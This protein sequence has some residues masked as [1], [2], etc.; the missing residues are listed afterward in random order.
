MWNQ[1]KT[2]QMKW[3]TM[4]SC[5]GAAVDLERRSASSKHT[6]TNTRFGIRVCVCECRLMYDP[7]SMLV[8]MCLCA[9][10]GN[11]WIFAFSIGQICF[12]LSYFDGNVDCSE[13]LLTSKCFLYGFSS[14]ASLSSFSFF[15][16]WLTWSILSLAGSLF[17]LFFVRLLN[18]QWLSCN[19]LPISLKLLHHNS[20][21][22][23]R[24]EIKASFHR[25]LAI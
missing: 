5:A 12:R 16:L 4:A 25:I 3:T 18:R 8:R 22:I 2:K 24:S 17:L 19:D 10:D 20:I 15:S 1:E 9:R 7:V 6:A 14:L 23:I 21:P 11:I 13:Y